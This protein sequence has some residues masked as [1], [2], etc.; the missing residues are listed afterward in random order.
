[1]TPRKRFKI[2]ELTMSNQYDP[3]NPLYRPISQPAGID[4]AAISKEAKR[5]EK[6]NRDFQIKVQ[7]DNTKQIDGKL[8][9]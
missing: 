5:A 9:I 4:Q 2:P 7:K 1:M 3:F 6:V 8:Y